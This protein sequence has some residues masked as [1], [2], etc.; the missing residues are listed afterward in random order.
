M[1]IFLGIFWSS[2]GTGGNLGRGHPGVYASRV[3]LGQCGSHWG[4]GGHPKSMK[5]T[6]RQ[7]RLSWNIFVSPGALEVFLEYFMLFW[8]SRD[9][10]GSVE[11]I[12]RN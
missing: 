3:F 10:T 8:G 11:A 12:L 1:R 4:S 7:W 2:C 6:L 5:V 9:I